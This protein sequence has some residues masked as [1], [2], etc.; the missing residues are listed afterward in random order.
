MKFGQHLRRAELSFN[1]KAGL[2][3]SFVSYKNLKKLLKRVLENYKLY[4][5]WQGGQNQFTLAEVEEFYLESAEKFMGVLCQDI[6]EVAWVYDSHIKSCSDKERFY[7]QAYAFLN[8]EAVRKICKK[9]D[10][11]VPGED[12]LSSMMKKLKIQNF[13]ADIQCLGPQDS[14][15]LR[16]LLAGEGFEESTLPWPSLAA[17]FTQDWT[18]NPDAIEHWGTTGNPEWICQRQKDSFEMNHEYGF[19]SDNESLNSGE[20]DPVVGPI[21]NS[22]PSLSSSL[23]PPVHPTRNTN[24]SYS[25]SIPLNHES[26][27]HPPPS[28]QQH[29]HS[30]LNNRHSHSTPII[31]P[32]QKQIKTPLR[33]NNHSLFPPENIFRQQ[34]PPQQHQ[35]HISSQNHTLLPPEMDGYGARS[36]NN[37]PENRFPPNNRPSWSKGDPVR[38][39]I[40]PNPSAREQIPSMGV[41][42]QYRTPQN[43]QEMWNNGSRTGPQRFS[44]SP[45]NYIQSRNETW[46]NDDILN[47]DPS[48]GNLIINYLPNEWTE[49][50][51]LALFSPCGEI[52][53]ARIVRERFSRRSKGFGFVKFTGRE[54]AQ[55]AIHAMNGRIMSGKQIKVSF[56][57]ARRSRAKANLFVSRFPSDWT[58]V[59]LKKLFEPFGEI[60]ECRVLR[61]LN[62]ESKRC[63]FVRYGCEQ[64]AMQAI[65]SL[66]SSFLPGEKCRLRVKIADRE[67]Y[68]QMKKQKA[69]FSNF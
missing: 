68:Q 27:V 55:R 30:L 48:D 66:N 32:L 65:I 28:T 39:T 7:L 60:I 64:S 35:Q 42:G 38:N 16:Q 20:S 19:W 53:S 46:G 51:L 13:F 18:T 3:L 37:G 57:K 31:S 21:I 47:V 4:S 41:I 23:T 67:R 15:A 40:T 34:P 50:E 69:V 2:D 22:T 33:P 36:W 52:L 43:P 29:R 10:K 1:D 24:N 6:L 54:E 56:A 45:P 9:F 5:E 12:I 59:A 8:T 11:H 25:S 61:T 62:G 17:G 26:M 14:M 44:H 58:S 49:I 63:G